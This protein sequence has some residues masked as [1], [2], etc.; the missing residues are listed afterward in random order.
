MGYEELA[1]WFKGRLER[2]V[3]DEPEVSALNGDP[4]DDK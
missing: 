2:V 1:T 3:T 4:T